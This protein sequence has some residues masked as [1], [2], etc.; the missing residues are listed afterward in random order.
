MNSSNEGLVH[1]WY[2]THSRVWWRIKKGHERDRQRH[3]PWQEIDALAEDEKAG[4][5][6]SLQRHLFHWRGNTVLLKIL[7]VW[8]KETL[9]L[10]DVF[11]DVSGAYLCQWWSLCYSGV[12]FHA[13]GNEQDGNQH[14][15]PRYVLMG[16][17]LP[18]FNNK[19]Y[20]EL[21]WSVPHLPR[22][23]TWAG[24]WFCSGGCRRGTWCFC[25]MGT[26]QCHIQWQVV[27]L[28][29]ENRVVVD[30]IRLKSSL[31]QEVFR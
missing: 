27:F 20:L 24:F 29:D 30:R 9:S 8:S 3:T 13:R 28:F 1:T 11:E 15:G 18:C 17:N 23:K 4:P 7:W 6:S 10:I 2:S 12:R 5:V 19:W 25:P 21:V 31:L 14:R 26:R 22:T 16:S